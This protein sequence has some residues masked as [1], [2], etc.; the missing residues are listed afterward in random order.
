MAIDLGK[1][2]ETGDPIGT[3]ESLAEH[4][5]DP[6]RYGSCSPYEEGKNKGCPS[7]HN[8]R[9]TEYRDRIGGRVGPGNCGVLSITPEGAAAV[10]IKAC[11]QY[12]QSGDDG[13][14]RN[15][16]KNG[17]MVQII[18]L[19]GDTVD[20]RGSRMM[21]AKRDPNCPACQKGNCQ[22]MQQYEEKREIPAFPRLGESKESEGISFAVRMR[23][24]L[25]QDVDR[26]K[27]NIALAGH[28]TTKKA[29]DGSK[30]T[31]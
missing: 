11:W 20:D 17:W 16:D 13:K 9:F 25:I 18:G 29:T 23:K 24:Q 15:A 28:D 30:G 12:Y 10:N 27:Q 26:E 4:A 3:K 5:L 1:A 14:R 6:R 19:E 21:H 2:A 31:K 7:Y 22:K 8:C